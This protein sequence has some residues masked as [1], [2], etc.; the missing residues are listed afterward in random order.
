[1]RPLTLKIQRY[2]RRLTQNELGHLANVASYDISNH[3]TGR[4]P[5]KPEELERVRRVL[6]SK[7]SA[8]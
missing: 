7:A 5:L 4:R 1:M 6:L 2:K 8:A 3:E